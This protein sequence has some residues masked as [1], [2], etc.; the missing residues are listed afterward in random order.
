MKNNRKGILLGILILA[1]LLA[2]LFGFRAMMNAYYDW[3]AKDIALPQEGTYVCEDL[4]ITMGFN[5]GVSYFE[6]DGKHILLS[7]SNAKTIFTAPNG[8][9]KAK[10]HWDRERDAIMLKFTKAPR[11]LDYDT[12]YCFVRTDRA[13]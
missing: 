3:H 1:L 2:G 7:P 12:W 10:F 6:I 8:E 11:D 9:Y 5:G 4:G 13:K